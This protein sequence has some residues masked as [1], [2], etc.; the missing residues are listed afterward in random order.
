MS[1]WSITRFNE[2]S[3]W[4]KMKL[5]FEILTNSKCLHQVSIEQI[6]CGS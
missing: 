6:S 1:K 2:R 5:P 4:V 3:F